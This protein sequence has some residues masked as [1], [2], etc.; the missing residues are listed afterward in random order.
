MSRQTLQ[1]L[2]F[3][4]LL[5]A[6]VLVKVLIS[7]TGRVLEERVQRSAEAPQRTAQ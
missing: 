2:I 6:V 4:A 3:L 1:L 7:R 5:A